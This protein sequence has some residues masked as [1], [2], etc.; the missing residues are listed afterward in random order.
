MG[1]SRNPPHCG[2]DGPELQIQ[3]LI[4]RSFYEQ[5][6]SHCHQYIVT[7]KISIV[8][9]LIILHLTNYVPL[10]LLVKVNRQREATTV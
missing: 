9:A 5:P 4:L 2:C 6:L 1:P 3:V 8:A 7:I 10:R